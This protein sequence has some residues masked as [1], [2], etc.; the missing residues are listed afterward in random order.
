MERKFNHLVTFESY[1]NEEFNPFKKEDW[2]ETGTSIRKGVGF[3][4]PEEEIEEGKKKVLNHRI[5]KGK[6]EEYLDID[7]KVADEYLKFWAKATDNNANPVWSDIKGKF[8]D[9]ASYDFSS[10]PG[11]RKLY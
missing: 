10:G 8:V 3:L 9:A 4:T 2:K 6:Y 5:R 11:G 7:P 1:T